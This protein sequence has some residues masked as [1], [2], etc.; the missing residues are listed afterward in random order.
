MKMFY[1]LTATSC[2]VLSS[3]QRYLLPCDVSIPLPAAWLL[4]ACLSFLHFLPS[5][6]LVPVLRSSFPGE[7]TS[8]TFSRGI[9]G[10]LSELPAEVPA[11][12]ACWLGMRV[13]EVL[14]VSSGRCHSGNRR[15]MFNLYLLFRGKKL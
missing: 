9:S 1:F 14:E 12:A 3:C 8:P 6:P 7:D 11:S 2:P 5:L 4:M 10:G 15:E 13:Q